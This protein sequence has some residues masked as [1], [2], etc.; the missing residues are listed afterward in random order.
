M[1]RPKSVYGTCARCGALL[2]EPCLNLRTGKPMAVGVHY[3][4]DKMPRPPKGAQRVDALLLKLN[5]RGIAL[6]HN[7]KE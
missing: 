3:G 6:R 4:R 1:A 2:G 5:E 7:E